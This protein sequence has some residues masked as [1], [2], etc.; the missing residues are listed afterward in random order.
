L[1]FLVTNC[2]IVFGLV[3]FDNALAVLYTLTPVSQRIPDLPSPL[4]LISA[5][6]VPASAYDSDRIQGLLDAVSRLKKKSRSFYLA[7]GVFQG[8]LRIDLILLYSFCR[9]ADD[10]VDNAASSDEAKAW[11]SK[12]KIY[13]SL[14]YDIGE[15]EATVASFVPAN[16]PASAQSALLLLPTWFLS[17]G[18]LGELLEGFETDLGFDREEDGQAFPIKTELD[19]EVYSARVAGTV[20][21]LCL[22]L[23]FAHLPHDIANGNRESL[24]RAGENMGIALQLVNISRDI[25]VDAKM[26]RV[27]LPTAWLDEVDLTPEAVARH[28][29]GTGVNQLKQKLLSKAFATYRNSRDAIEGLPQ[30]V[31]GPMRVAVESYME[32]GRV[33]VSRPPEPSAERA[34][35][36]PAATVPVW[37]RIFVAWQ[38]LNG[39]KKYRKVKHS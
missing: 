30:Q 2:L 22:D 17:Q 23:V 24:T 13:L 31:R 3:A 26:N 4:A 28:P 10:L 39:P 19:L 20:A 35:R 27:Y 33:L 32:I 21:H 38:A 37:R 6:L 16:F 8:K 18:P 25:E 14:A 15:K 5:L 1:F 12:L 36:N 34:S 7:S 9:V 11:I 29:T